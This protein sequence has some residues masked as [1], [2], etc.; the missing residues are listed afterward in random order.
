[1]DRTSFIHIK[2]GHREMSRSDRI[3][4][5]LTGERLGI[6]YRPVDDDRSRPSSKNIVKYRKNGDVFGGPPL[7]G[8]KGARYRTSYRRWICGDLLQDRWTFALLHSGRL[9]NGGRGWKGVVVLGAQ[10]G[11]TATIGP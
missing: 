2:F 1:M 10:G 9:A 6:S 8:E 4:D 7:S 3:R 5:L 11:L